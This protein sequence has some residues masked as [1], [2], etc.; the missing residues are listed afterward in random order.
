MPNEF[1]ES[2]QSSIPTVAIKSLPPITEDKKFSSITHDLRSIVGIMKIHCDRSTDPDMTQNTEFMPAPVKN[3]LLSAKKDVDL[4][5]KFF[6]DSSQLSN[7][8][9][10]IKG[11]N[12]EKFN[13]KIIEGLLDYSK[14][15][16][17]N[18]KEKIIP[19]STYKD[20]YF[21][22]IIQ[23]QIASLSEEI[24]EIPQFMNLD[25][26][27]VKMELVDLSELIPE[28][29][30]EIRGEI[31]HRK[32]HI[33]VMPVLNPIKCSLD[34]DLIKKIMENFIFNSIKYT[35][36]S[37][38]PNIIISFQQPDGQTIISVTDFG[39]GIS[40]ENLKKFNDFN[41]GKSTRFAKEYEGTGFGLYNAA[42]YAI[43]MGGY[44]EIKSDGEGQ[45]STF[46]VKFAK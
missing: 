6:D 14:I 24:V 22:K 44:V 46:S 1:R 20:N 31:Q 2:N 9:S 8:A 30:D 4:L 25:T 40:K 3:F 18:I 42:S 7:R 41:P 23:K 12:N 27:Q 39:I 38:E 28:I 11:S 19:Y 17:T 21:M 10:E 15:T 34:R 5:M 29:S 26:Y 13:Q 43:K 37:K 35:D 36:P 16:I 32:N 33:R 45:G